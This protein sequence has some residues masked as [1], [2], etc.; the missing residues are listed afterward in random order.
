MYEY[1]RRFS[2]KSLGEVDKGDYT[3]NLTASIIG[4]ETKATFIGLYSHPDAIR[5]YTA[6]TSPG[7]KELL[8][9]EMKTAYPRGKVESLSD[10]DLTLLSFAIEPLASLG[11]N[12]L[13]GLD[14]RDFSDFV[15][16]VS[17]KNNLAESK[18][19]SV[20]S[21]EFKIP[22]VFTMVCPDSYSVARSEQ[23]YNI[24]TAKPEVLSR[25]NFERVSSTSNTPIQDLTCELKANR[26]LS[27]AGGVNPMDFEGVITYTQ[28][29][30]KKFT[31]K[32]VG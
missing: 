16:L 31:V 6:G 7:F 23:G 22:D 13:S 1:S 11:V 9:A 17:L 4:I 14:N 15:L 8:E 10:P 30:V 19:K 2:C 24:I 12:G 3:F 18:I 28:D 25:I 29:L 27:N 32:R 26:E 21:L 5:S 20:Q